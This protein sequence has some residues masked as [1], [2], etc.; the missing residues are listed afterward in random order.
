MFAAVS[1]AQLPVPVGPE[2]QV[3]SHVI[4]A[5]QFGVPA[6]APDGSFVVVWTSSI[7]DGRGGGVFGQRY[8]AA[9]APVGL[10]FTVTTGSAIWPH[11]ASG[12]QGQFA[13]VWASLSDV[14][15]RRYDASGVPL[16]GAFRVNTYTT[17]TQNEPT[18]ALDAAGGMVIVWESVQDGDQS[19]IYGQ[20]YDTAGQP[21][22]LEF[23]VNSYTTGRQRHAA[24]AS[25]AGGNF[26]VVWESDFEVSGQRYDA[27]GVAQGLEF[28][29]NTYT[30]GASLDPFVATEGDGDFF[31]VF[32]SQYNGLFR[33]SGRR[34]Q[35]DGTPLGPQFL[36]NTYPTGLQTY[37]N[38]STEPQGGFTVVWQGALDQD[39]SGLGVF[40]RQYNASGVPLDAEFRVNTYTT[41]HQAV[42]FV[43]SAQSG[44]FVVAWS[45]A[46]QD[47]DAYGVFAQRFR[48]DLV[49]RDGFESG[50]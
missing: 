46:Q 45:S 34:Y 13:V 43:A 6:I 9:G 31:V 22:G 11:V 5:Q 48:P 30:L 4:G 12:A 29:V 41:S 42:P 17:D 27:S 39:G 1:A 14:F 2:F 49:F 24:V 10:E 32:Q 36:I 47:G 35:S 21:V 25:A 50:T 18:L 33:V 44:E 28:L 37:P 38:V 20:R 26:V 15:A 19:G 40:G 7:N 16:D 8:D 3:N 23:R